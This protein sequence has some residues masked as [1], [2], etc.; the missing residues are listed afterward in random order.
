[1]NITLL[2]TGGADGVPGLFS[3]SRVSQYARTHGGKEVRTRSAA[4]LDGHIKLD[5]GPDTWAQV[6]AQN[7]NPLDWT[8][9]LMTHAD[10]DHFA[11]EEFQ[12]ALYP[13]TE[14]TL[15]PFSIYGND[16]II[17]ALRNRYP[18]WPIDL[19]V[20][21]SFLPFTL[22][23]YTI[24]PI[25]ANH[26]NGEDAHNFLITHNNKTLLYATDTGIWLPATWNFLRNWSIDLLIIECTEGIVP[27][28][29]NGHLDTKECLSVVERLRRLGTLVPGSTVV[30]THHS[31]NGDA[32]HAELEAI[33]NPHDIIVGYDGLSLTIG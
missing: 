29:Y 17:S 9:V 5:F 3:E 10:A 32:T 8:A 25:S 31:H 15:C 22:G 30:T 1:M 13:F 33:L 26:S 20:T 27:T 6:R 23:E 11:I 7:L 4:L 2:G 14:S 18:D 12:Y 28:P 24:T 19:N 16:H 21:R